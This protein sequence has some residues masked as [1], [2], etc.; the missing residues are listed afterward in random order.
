MEISA[1]WLGVPLDLWGQYDIA[2][3]ELRPD[4]AQNVALAKVWAGI[5]QTKMPLHHFL[6]LVGPAGTGKTQLALSLGIWLAR[7]RNA[8]VVF[9]LAPDL[10]EKLRQGQKLDDEPLTYFDSHRSIMERCS[11]RAD[12][13]ILDDIGMEK[14]TDWAVEQLSRIIDARY[15]LQ[16][17]T[18]ITTNVAPDDLPPRITSRLNGGEVLKFSGLDMRSELRRRR[19]AARKQ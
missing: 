18:I 2:R 19:E 7:N 16:K 10:L 4:N 1:R 3:Y 13:F 9:Y 8:K 6:C 15:R 11:E 17:R 5:E 14:D 12:V